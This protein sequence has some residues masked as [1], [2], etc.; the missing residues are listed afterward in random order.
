MYSW[1]Q[2]KRHVQNIIFMGN[3]GLSH[4]MYHA[5]LYGIVCTVSSLLPD[6]T[7]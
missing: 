4:I 5:I 2:Q 3:I 7:S 6:Y 1:L